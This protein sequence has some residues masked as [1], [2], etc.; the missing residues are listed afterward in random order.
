MTQITEGSMQRA[1]RVAIKKALATACTPDNVAAR[2]IGGSYEAR[3]EAHEP[4]KIGTIGIRRC[5]PIDG[6]QDI[7][8]W[9]AGW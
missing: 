5:R 7:Q 8:E 6:R 2:L 9:M 3:A 4:R 1:V